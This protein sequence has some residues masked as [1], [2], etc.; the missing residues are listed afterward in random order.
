MS[1]SRAMNRVSRQRRMVGANASNRVRDAVMS[2][3]PSPAKPALVGTA[4]KPAEPAIEAKQKL[5]IKESTLAESTRKRQPGVDYAREVNPFEAYVPPPSVL[6]QGRKA[7]MAMDDALSSWA[8]D[9]FAQSWAFNNPALSAFQE[10]VTF[11]GYAYLSELTQRPEYR[12]MSE[13]IATEMTR[14]WIRLNATGDDADGKVDKKKKQ[15]LDAKVKKLDEEMRV[16]D[17]RCAE[18]DGWFGRSHIYIDTGDTDDRDEL[19]TTIGDGDDKVSRAK[20]KGKKGFLR[21]IKNIE[22]IWCYPAFYNANDPLKNDWYNPTRWFVQA[23][24]LHKTR[25]LTFVG[26]EVPDLLKPAYAFG[27]LSLSQMAKPYIDNWLRTRQAV[28]DLVCSFSVSGIYTNMQAALTGEDGGAVFDRIDMFNNTRSNRGAYALDRDTEEFF[29]VSTPLSGLDHL[30]AQAQEQ[31]SSVSG[32]PL[33]V[34]LGITPTGLNASSEGELR[35]FYDFIHAYQ[36]S[37]FRDK[38][39]CVLDFI[40]LSLFGEIDPSITFEFEPLWSLDEKAQAEVEEIEMRTNV[41]YADAGVVSPEEVRGVIIKKPDSEFAGLDP[42]DVPDLSEEEAEGFDPEAGPKGGGK[43]GGSSSGSPGGGSKG[44]GGAM[45]QRPPRNRRAARAVVAADDAA[46]NE[47]D[48]PR[49][50]GKFASKAGAGAE[51]KAEVEAEEKIEQKNYGG[52]YTTDFADPKENYF[53]TVDKV[54]GGPPKKS[55]YYRLMVAALIKESSTYGNEGSISGLKAKLA[56]SYADLAVKLQNTGKLAD[57]FKASK[58]AIKLGHKPT[59]QG[60]SVEEMK[61]GAHEKVKAAFADMPDNHNPDD[62]SDKG[63]FEIQVDKFEIQL[64]NNLKAAPAKTDPLSIGKE[65]IKAA[66]QTGVSPEI[67]FQNMTD[68]E[69]AAVKKQYGTMTAAHNKAKGYVEAAENQKKAQEAAA[70]KT[71]AGQEKAKAEAKAKA[72]A[73]AAEMNNPEVKAHYEVLK[74]VGAD[75]HLNDSIIKKIIAKHKLKIT[76]QEGA[77]I[78]AYVGSHYGPVNKQLRKGVVSTEQWNYA[79]NLDDALD[80]MP[81]Y[82]GLVKR[83]AP[84]TDAEFQRYKNA[85]GKVLPEPGF[86][87]AGVHSKL[88]GDYSFEME[89]KTARDIRAFNPSEGGGEVV[90]K[91][92]TAFFVSKIEGK[93]IY[94]KEV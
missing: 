40:Q 63:D 39:K 79:K 71:K 22:P 87:S 4:A 10:G 8:S 91:N 19:K 45:D 20:F 49:D 36:E 68:A 17:V 93:T 46:W 24:E 60:S 32:I 84:L 33:I 53:D 23:K 31:M 14:K 44:G 1:V 42:D 35:V 54:L 6:P 37:F 83:G 27:G 90:F 77:Y 9:S 56:Q 80:K 66:A 78:S 18:H 74:A 50:K 72:D 7:K 3:M 15:A 43:G 88:W 2:V 85:V 34:L 92:N 5:K 38:L 41:G 30:Q 62:F 86:Q 47:S 75:Y 64:Q 61:Q 26:R 59:I 16:M 67:A 58:K 73:I 51:P 82:Q 25:L 81:V 12:R 69:Q 11:L 28:T 55:H 76:P 21:G 57:A 70:A 65:K 13:R 29:N 52:L 94:M 48:H 89:S